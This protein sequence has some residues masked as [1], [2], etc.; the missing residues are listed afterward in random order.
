MILM[1]AVIFAAAITIQPGQVLQTFAAE[2]PSSSGGGPQ[3]TNP[4]YEFRAAWVASVVNI[5]WPS[6]KGLDSEVQKKEF[7]KIAETLKSN[8]MNAVIVQ[9]RPV[10]D[11]FYPSAYTTWS[12]YLSGVQGKAPEPYYDPLAFI[13]ETAHANN[14]EFHAWVNPFRIT[15]KG[16]SDLQSLAA[17][18]PARKHPEWVVNYDN[19]LFFNP[20]IPEANAFIIE[21]ILEIVK[22]YDVDAIHMDDYFYPYPV[23]G[24]VFPDQKEYALYG[25]GKSLEDFRR[26]N[27]DGLVKELNAAIKR[28]KSYVKFGI[29]PFG[30]WR[31]LK[32]DPTGSDTTASVMNYDSLYADTRTWIKNGWIDYIMPQIYWDFAEPAAP[33]VKVLNFWMKEM[34]LN[35]DVHLYTGNATYKI[36]TDSRGGGWKIPGELSNQLNKN[37]ES[38]I[39]KGSAFYNM[40]S[41]AADPLA[42]IS[43][44]VKKQYQTLALI[45]PMTWLNQGGMT[46]VAPK[47]LTRRVSRGVR[48]LIDNHSIIETAK[49][50]SAAASGAVGITAAD[51][52]SKAKEMLK[53][54]VIYR[55]E[56]QQTVDRNNPAHILA[57]L[58][59][60]DRRNSCFIDLTADKNKQYTYAVTAIDRLY[61]ESLAATSSEL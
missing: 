36:G 56:G 40:T 35:P 26:A 50:G 1:I 7:Q 4:K 3:T 54:Y 55:V 29:S 27:V 38:A 57:V 22:N 12:E 37:R 8:N 11:A 21:S 42:E 32:D 25:G 16:N 30:V 45:P 2:T 34:Q 59:K 20:G 52:L 28:E 61:N 47:V 24:V 15:M 6:K 31:N 17:D 33:Y 43:G 60:S 14:L 5:D 44:V 49:T 51:S 48:I 46:F 53:G 39:V 58:P 18:H 41:V 23:S 10:S 13:I 19:Q 9:V